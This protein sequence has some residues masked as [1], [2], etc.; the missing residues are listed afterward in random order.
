MGTEFGGVP[1]TAR[2]SS[3]SRGT[4]TAASPNCA[5]PRSRFG[6]SGFGARAPDASAAKS[7]GSGGFAVAVDTIINSVEYVQERSSELWQVFVP[8]LVRNLK[9]MF[10]TQHY[11]A[12]DRSRSGAF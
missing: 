8:F 11:F 6:L 4:A 10:Q 7:V 3:L 5:R 12:L 1:A 2:A 9:Q